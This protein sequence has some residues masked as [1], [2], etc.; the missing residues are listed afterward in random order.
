SFTTLTP[1]GQ[2]TLNSNYRTREAG[3]TREELD[4][5]RHELCLHGK[6]QH[7]HEKKQEPA[8][9]V[10]PPTWGSRNQCPGTE[11]RW[12]LPIPA[13]W[14][15]RVDKSQREESNLRPMVYE[16]IALPL[17]Y[18]GGTI[19]IIS[20]V[21]RRSTGGSMDGLS[22]AASLAEISPHI[23]GSTI[24]T[25]YHP[26]YAQ[27]VLR[28]F[29]GE[30][31]R[32][33]IDLREASVR[34]AARSIE[35]PATPSTFVMLLRKHLRGGRVAGCVQWEWDR[36]VTLN[37]T[38]ME[39][40]ERFTYQLI[41]ELIGTRGNLLLFRDGCL[42]Q[43]LRSDGRNTVGC[44]YAGLPSQDKL[45]PGDVLPAQ[46]ERWLADGTAESVLVRRIEGIGRQTAA[47]V[48]A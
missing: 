21:N 45:D 3:K 13:E 22:I 44:P 25:V 24:R 48:I 47:D 11:L 39:G 1:P 19:G 12:Q 23:I 41:A 36:V 10:A 15:A 16:T 31:V 7:K 40:V 29:D 33:V 38:R 34:T 18:A 4:L 6:R 20:R 17:S 46:M 43:S 9:G 8:R 2:Y 27:F 5:S 28:L 35:N 32:L 42:L 37:I 30:D 14:E 26:D